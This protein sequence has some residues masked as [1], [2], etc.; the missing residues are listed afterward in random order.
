MQSGARTI[1]ESCSFAL[2]SADLL[3]A[4]ASARRFALHMHE[5]F[6]VVVV[7]AGSASL[8]SNRWSKKAQA[9][10]VFFFNP[11]E[12]HG[13][14]SLDQ[15]VHYEVLY[16]SRDL[17]V[18]C[19]SG[20]GCRTSIPLFQTDVLRKCAATEAFID[21]LSSATSGITQVETALGI[22]L[23]RC[24]F[25]TASF[26]EHGMSAVRA[27][28]DFIEERYMHAVSTDLLARH[29]G[30]HKSH[31][32]RTFHRATGIAPQTY[33]RQL[34][35]ARARDLICEGAELCEAAQSVG[36]CDQA[37]LTREFK[38]VYGVPPGRLS[39]D[40]RISRH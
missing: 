25:E 21:A 15:S 33:L 31:F 20:V 38:K 10:D 32:I 11:F 12:V 35:I 8:Y 14:G 16:P 6:S 3:R 39:R 18:D 24:S 22:L 4:R 34:R 17:I 7:I 29:V 40:L 1:V 13:G 2:G 27:A 9:G 28:C 26:P 36:F 19:L 5:T 37:H 30:L 23:R